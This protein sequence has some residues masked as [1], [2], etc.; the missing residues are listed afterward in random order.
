LI[1]RRGA[2]GPRIEYRA[3]HRDGRVVWLESSPSLGRDS[4]GAIAGI[5]DTARDVTER[6]AMERALIA[7][8]EEAEV[9]AEAKSEF[10]ANMSHELKT[11]LTSAIGFADAL[12]DY[13]DL[14]TR[15]RRFAR[16]IRTASLAL[17]S[18]VN[19]ILDYSRMERGQLS[20]DPEFFALKSYMEDLLGMFAVDAAEKGLSL[21]LECTSD[22]ENLEIF[23]DPNRL[24][25]ILLNLVGNA[26]K[27]TVSG[28]VTLR[29]RCE[30]KDANDWRLRCEVADTGPG[31]AADDVGRLFQRFSR[32]EGR[33]RFGGTGLGLAI[34]KG[35]VTAM[36]GEIGV[37]TELGSGSRFWFEIPVETQD[38]A[39]R[40]LAS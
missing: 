19:D 33:G 11:P 32:I 29:V 36:G 2:A 23:A 26:V 21:S 18:T 40:A 31:I 22:L 1:A 5:V 15:A 12:N 9:A 14:D 25:Q 34:C 10:L 16:G 20:C 17:L 38:R 35:L 4:G 39:M 6:K 13:C 3:R 28:S 24:R 30:D 37:S 7:A 27:F 8:R